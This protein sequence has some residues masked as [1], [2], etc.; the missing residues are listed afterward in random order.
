VW[1]CVVWV[2]VCVW[3]VY[4]CVCLC[5]VKY[6]QYILVTC[7]RGKKVLHGLYSLQLQ[8][9]C[10]M[11]AV[12]RTHSLLYRFGWLKQCVAVQN[13]A[14]AAA[15]CRQNEMIRSVETLTNVCMS[16]VFLNFISEFLSKSL[17]FLLLITII[18]NLRPKNR[19]PKISRLLAL[20]ITSHLRDKGTCLIMNISSRNM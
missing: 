12:C 15:P 13:A 9:Y 10:N 19:D 8:A 3:C 1:V 2:C 4:A 18:T 14:T 17:I 20:Q 5:V 6:N 11:K 7:I 16:V